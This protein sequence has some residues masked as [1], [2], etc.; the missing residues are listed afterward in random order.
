MCVIDSRSVSRKGHTRKYAHMLSSQLYEETTLYSETATARESPSKVLHPDMSRKA[1][2]RNLTTSC[3][4]VVRLSARRASLRAAA[5]AGSVCRVWF[6]STMIFHAVSLIA[7]S[8]H[9]SIS[10]RMLSASLTA[11]LTLTITLI[12]SRCCLSYC[13]QSRC[14]LSYC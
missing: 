14:C 10:H 7:C 12:I 2:W 1:K 13:C 11:V 4:L 3:G 8:R 6:Q 5:G 9:L